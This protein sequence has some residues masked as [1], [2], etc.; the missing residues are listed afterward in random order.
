MSN[1]KV[2]KVSE[3]LKKLQTADGFTLVEVMVSMG[4]FGIVMAFVPMAF[5]AHLKFNTRME[6]KTSAIE[7]AQRVLDSYRIIDPADLP[8]SGSAPDQTFQINNK[9][10]V[11]KSK[12]CA[13]PEYCA[14]NNSRHITVEV[15]CDADSCYS[16]ET[17]FTRLK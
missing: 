17:V 1:A 16:V 14:S 15:F 11:V 3:N 2:F 5:M 9:S 13:K 8:D 6:Q 7:V 4:I 12:F 10:Y